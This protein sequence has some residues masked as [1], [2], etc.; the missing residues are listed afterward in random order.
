MKVY[1]SAH[2]PDVAEEAALFINNNNDNPDIHFHVVSTWHSKPR[3][4]KDEQCTDWEMTEKVTVNF[5]E[6]EK[7]D[8]LVLIAGP[9]KYTGGKF[10]EAGYAL[11]LGQPVVVVG[12]R[13]N[14]MLFHENV[15]LCE[16]LERLAETLISIR[17][18]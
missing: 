6:I 16:G 3:I 8:V 5:C 4:K 18:Q 17:N 15:T 11:G 9:Y 14:F 12:R 1:I 13:E 2:S 10:V 7:C